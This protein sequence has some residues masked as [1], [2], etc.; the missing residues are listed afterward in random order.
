MPSELSKGID[1]LNMLYHHTVRTA[2][3]FIEFTGLAIADLFIKISR[4]QLRMDSDRFSA[5]P[6]NM[7]LSG[8]DDQRTEPFSAEKLLNGN[9][10]DKV[11][12]FTVI[13]HS[14]GSNRQTVD[15]SDEMD[16]TFIVA[17][18]FLIKALLVNKNLDTDIGCVLGELMKN[19]NIH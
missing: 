13:K 1:F 18:K 11:I 9:P 6:F 7:L 8:L 2:L 16:S 3:F 4:L 15:I 5:D 17:I 19:L 10:A 12:I 14:A